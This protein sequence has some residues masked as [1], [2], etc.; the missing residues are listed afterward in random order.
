[1][2]TCARPWVSAGVVLLLASLAVPARARDLGCNDPKQVLI[3][4]PLNPVG[5]LVD[6]PTTTPLAIE[7]VDRGGKMFFEFAVVMVSYESDGTA[8]AN[9][10]GSIPL[11][12]LRW[13][14]LRLP[15][16]L[17]D[18]LTS[19]VHNSVV[20]YGG[21]SAVANLTAGPLISVNLSGA[22]LT[23]VAS[24]RLRIPA[25]GVTGNQVGALTGVAAIAGHGST[26]CSDDSP[27]GSWYNPGTKFVASNPD[28]ACAAS[29]NAPVSILFVGDLSKVELSN[30]QEIR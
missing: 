9:G 13:R 20:G 19:P 8:V 11:G 22:A 2:T 27:F 18:G 4:E 5:P 23:P 3:I 30:L 24:A 1:M 10:Y 15:G 7:A 26:D 14:V 21:C 29:Q 6:S 25:A 12:S 16:P 17:S 28:L